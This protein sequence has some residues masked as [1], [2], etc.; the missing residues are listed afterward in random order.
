MTPLEEERLPG[1]EAGPV[2]EG[3]WQAEAFALTVHLHERGAFTWPEWA[4]ALSAQLRLAGGQT[5]SSDYYQAW[6]AA[7]EFLAAE[8]ALAD[9][10]AMRRRAAEWR[11]AF[12]TTPHGRPVNLQ[13]S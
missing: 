12:E 1:H 13:P 5:T 6:V 9:R 11:R 8:K 7:L 2:F 3:P 4:E 10:D